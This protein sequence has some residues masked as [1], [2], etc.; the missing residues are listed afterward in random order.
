MRKHF[1]SF[2]ISLA[3]I[4]VLTA[5]SQVCALKQTGKTYRSGAVFVSNSGYSSSQ[6]YD[7]ANAIITVISKESGINLTLEKF[8]STEELKK[9]FLAGRIDVALFGPGDVVEL[10]AEGAGVI[11]WATYSHKNINERRMCFWSKSDAPI[12]KVANITNKTLI[13]SNFEILDLLQLKKFLIENNIN[14]PIRKVFKA[15]THISSENSAFM[16]LSLGEGDLMWRNEDSTFFLKIINPG[17][18]KAVAPGICSKTNTMARDAVLLNAKTFDK[19][20]VETV[21]GLAATF[22]RN[23]TKYSKE[24]PETAAAI[25]YMK[26]AQATIVPADVKDYQ[27]E[28]A[29]YKQAKT[30]GWLDEAKF[31]MER[32]KATQPGQPVDLSLSFKECKVVCDGAED[33]T[34]CIDKCLK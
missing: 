31:I 10:L 32:I 27:P 33:I 21:M 11:P 34:D 20:D 19:N 17:V 22:A 30:N 9:E 25:Q 23:M 13:E 3:A 1:I 29:L 5:P 14:D 15:I 18:A 6:Q 28:V 4:A 8:N 12:T 24:Y 16:A 7:F 26:M 2:C